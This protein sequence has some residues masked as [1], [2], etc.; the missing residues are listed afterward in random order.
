MSSCV[1]HD[2]AWWSFLVNPCWKRQTEHF[3]QTWSSAG[4]CQQDLPELL[5]LIKPSWQWLGRPGLQ[6]YMYLEREVKCFW[7]Y[8]F[9][10]LFELIW[11]TE[12][13][14]IWWHT[15]KVSKISVNLSLLKINTVNAFPSLTNPVLQ[16]RRFHH[17][18]ALLTHLKRHRERENVNAENEATTGGKKKPK[19]FSW[20]CSYFCTW[21]YLWELSN[22]FKS[23]IHFV[24]V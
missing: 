18:T 20:N 24:I 16:R 5:D 17:T 2:I 22:Y 10:W 19:Q 23:N 7:L 9:F 14:E 11:G 15:Q 13:V 6:F 3:Y 8:I 12:K 21:A 1:L 4:S